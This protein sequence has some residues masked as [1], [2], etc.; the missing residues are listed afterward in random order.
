MLE[1]VF[2]HM[3][4]A[5]A[6]RFLDTLIVFGEVNEDAGGRPASVDGGLQMRLVDVADGGL[7]R[8]VHGPKGAAVRLI[9]AEV[10]HELFVGAAD[11]FEEA[12]GFGVKVHG[13][14]FSVVSLQLSV[15]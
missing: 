8:L 9:G 5:A 12:L 4:D 10:G 3:L 11:V 14:E 7:Q 15:P 13:R 1:A 6:R 2:D